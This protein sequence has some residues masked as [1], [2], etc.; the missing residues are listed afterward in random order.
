M[1]I[2][3]K[4][5]YVV[6]HSH[7]D[8][9][10][11]F[12]LEDSNLLLVENMDYLIDVLEQDESFESYTFDG[13]MSVIQEYLKIRPEQRS[14]I[15]NLIQQRRIYVGPWYTQTDSLLV[16]TESVIRNLLY[17]T[18]LATQMGHRMNIG[19]LPDIFGQNSYLP[20]IFQG[21]EID[22]SILQRGIHEDEL[23]N[24]LNF[25]WKSPDGKSVKA[26]NLFLGYG[27]GKFLS[28]DEPY[29]REHLSPILE[30]LVKLNK[31]TNHLLLP[32]GGDQVLVR[33]QFPAV[34]EDLNEIDPSSE[35][36]LSNYESFMEDTW[37]ENG[38]LFT[39]EIEGELITP[40]KSR[41]H[42][43]IRSQRYDVKQLN[44]A[45]EN[46][47][48]Y[49]L[50][51]LM[52]I[53]QSLGLT[54]RQTWLDH[55]WKQLF[56]V[57]AHD[58]IGGCNSDA[59]NDEILGRLHRVDHIIDGLINI[60]KK[61][62]TWA[63]ANK[64]DEPNSPLVV[65]N[66]RPYLYSGSIDAVVFT[67]GSDFSIQQAD[68]SDVP[69][70]IE[71]QSYVSGGKKIAVTADGES[72]IELP[73]YYRTSVVLQA[74]AVPA[75]GY[76]TYHIVEGVSAAALL[77]DS[78]ENAIS[79]NVLRVCFENG[80]LCVEHVH[81][82]TVIHDFLSFENQADAGDSYDFSPLPG[83]TVRYLRDAEMLAVEKADHLQR[84]TVKHRCLIPKDL[85]ERKENVSS[86]ELD[87]ITTLELRENE[88]FVR[89]THEIENCA[90]DHRVRVLLKTPTRH[91]KESYA[92]QAFSIIR[93]TT[94]NP[95]L[96][97]W[98]DQGF[99]EAPVPIYPLENFAAVSDGDTTFAVIT[100]GIKEYEVLPDTREFALTLYRSVGLLGRDDLLWRPGRAS[101]INNLV[102]HT[103]DAQLQKSLTFEYAMYVE[104]TD[105]QPATLFR[106]TDMYRKRD[107]AYQLQTLNTFEER[108]ERFE[109]PKP[110]QELSSDY[111]L[112]TI[113]NDEV[114]MSICKQAYDQD[115]VV[116]RFFNPTDALQSFSVKS[117][118]FSRI[119]QTNLYERELEAVHRA[120]SIPSKGYVTIKM[121]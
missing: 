69:F 109:I 84:M 102:V 25:V 17:G 9:E 18:R 106:L 104:D 44:H 107:T 1:T 46:K 121:S 118:F 43:T 117:E 111:S 36:V 88:S 74:E 3:E 86:V 76:S 55:A 67:N 119:I 105:L 10:W 38:H 11:Y 52:V 97:N 19:Y 75:M 98:R 28:A 23:N 120:V 14:R 2:K 73:G 41:I 42:N 56:D 20:S 92:D 60:A 113:D 59:T 68:G 95:H 66:T 101:G 8:R 90:K 79:N 80:R 96:E 71:H 30:K 72:E 83:D 22:Y 65:F 70:D 40:Q 4:K 112:F 32:S 51:P 24:D 100:R 34:V 16:N 48:L 93:R 21:F 82:G 77:V 12:T 39:T 26:N 62:L 33:R 85:V 54:Y 89:I 53:A 6:A 58:S 61:Q 35:Y 94:T 37:K 27:P 87:V 31:S 29:F 116:V 49:V 63:I 114:F 5:V 57:H 91:V 103:P 99:A 115:G 78:K 13:Q 47:M 45:V 64:S 50:E 81:S 15:E 110:I 108:L 7:W